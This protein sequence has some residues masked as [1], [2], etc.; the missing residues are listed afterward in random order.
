M[1][2]KGRDLRG[3]GPWHSLQLPCQPQKRLGASISPKHFPTILLSVDPKAG[4]NEATK[5]P[6]AQE[7]SQLLKL[8]IEKLG[9]GRMREERR[10]VRGPSRTLFPP[11]RGQR[12]GGVHSL[13]LLGAL[14]RHALQRRVREASRAQ[15]LTGYGGR[16]ESRVLWGSLT[17][18]QGSRASQD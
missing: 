16:W 8:F 7:E 14:G 18:S 2:L 3:R 1:D 15:W 6:H 17:G 9:R 11:P 10:G 5:G 13:G 12:S 4:A